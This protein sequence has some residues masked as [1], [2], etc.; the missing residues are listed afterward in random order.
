MKY[1][2]STLVLIF[3]SE[4]VTAQLPDGISFQAL[5][6]DNQGE[7]V[8]GEEVYVQVSLLPESTQAAADYLERHLATSTNLGHVEFEIG[9]GEAMVGQF[10]N[11]DWMTSYFL[12]IEL[13]LDQGQTYNTLSVGELLSVPYTL[14]A[15][16]SLSGQPGEE[17]P[18]GLPGPQGPQGERG[19]QG[20]I[21][22]Q[23]IPSQVGITG[24][25]GN[26]G[27]SGPMGVAGPDGPHGLQG[28][29]GPTGEK[30]QIGPQGNSGPIGP[31]GPLGPQGEAGV[32][33]P[34]GPQGL[35]G[36]PDG[37]EGPQGDPGPDQ[38]EQGPQGPPGPQGPSGST[39]I[40]PAGPAGL[41]GD[42]GI[43]NMEML[44]MPPA[45]GK[46]YLDNGSNRQ[47]GKPGF[48]FRSVPTDPWVDI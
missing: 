31:T 13:S 12:K 14:L 21:G 45:D 15:E 4:V 36:G 16:I 48:R 20:Q 35:G 30:G 8:T 19:P 7:L 46:L 32:A 47:D 10:A 26:S 43:T 5:V 33:G 1:L 42:S 29:Q 2:L 18:A 22:P 23:G 34:A 39:P 27:P 37:P 41:N 3:C 11:L 28:A 38:G 6:I 9:R 40:C 17:G 25:A 24:P 44:A